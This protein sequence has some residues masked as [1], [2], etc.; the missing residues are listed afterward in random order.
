MT[1]PGL[2]A[3]RSS[4]VHRTEAPEATSVTVT[5]VPKASVGLAQV[6]AGE[7]YHDATPL[8]PCAGAAAV[9]AGADTGLGA[10]GGGFGVTAVAAGG[11][12][13]MGAWGGG[14]VVVVGNTCRND[15]FTT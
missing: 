14:S 4:T 7:P 15:T 12:L 3:S 10:D 13:W 8:I 1:R 9:G 6:P 2:C 5:T 11:A